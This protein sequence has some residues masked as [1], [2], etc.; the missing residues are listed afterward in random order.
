MPQ[1]INMMAI[2]EDSEVWSTSFLTNL[3]EQE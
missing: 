1:I 3:L 2:K